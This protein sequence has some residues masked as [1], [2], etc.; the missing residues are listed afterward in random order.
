MRV[1]FAWLQFELARVALISGK[2]VLCATFNAQT[3]KHFTQIQSFILPSSGAV[4][5]FRA[6]HISI[7]FRF[8]FQ[9]PD[10]AYTQ[11]IRAEIYVTVVWL[12]YAMQ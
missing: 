9:L 11:R 10:V 3:A 2:I 6:E 1:T 4:L 8:Q 7:F 12:F 5:C